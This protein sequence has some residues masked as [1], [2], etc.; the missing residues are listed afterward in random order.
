MAMQQSMTIEE[1][2]LYWLSLDLRVRALAERL[3]QR[4]AVTV[5]DL[6]ASAQHDHTEP[7]GLYRHSLEVALKGLEEFEGN[8]V[9]ERRP[10]GSVDSFRKQDPHSTDQ[11]L[12]HR[13]GR[14]QT[15]LPTLIPIHFEIS[16]EAITPKVALSQRTK[17][18][19]RKGM[20]T[21]IANQYSRGDRD[22]ARNALT[23]FVTAWTGVAKQSDPER[24]STRS[25]TASSASIQR[26]LSGA[27]SL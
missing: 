21:L 26:R 3:L 24:I 14:T 4:F 27:S 17:E 5:G 13:Q 11:N 15:D 20:K 2:I 23:L 8:M 9:M 12:S 16:D 6:P 18:P 22:A 7:G 10:D 25:N 19:W 1:Q